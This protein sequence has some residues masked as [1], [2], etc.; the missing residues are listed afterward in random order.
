MLNAALSDLQERAPGRLLGW[1][2]T[3]A[4][5]T[6]KSYA[7]LLKDPNVYVIDVSRSAIRAA[8]TSEVGNAD[9]PID[10]ITPQL[11]WEL[12]NL[13]IVSN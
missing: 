13:Q 3:Q 10:L 9:L 4:T 12:E 7:I 6:P 11:Y 1:V 5:I 2:Q 8:Y